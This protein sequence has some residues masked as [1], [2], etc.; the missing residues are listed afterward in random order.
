[1]RTVLR[2]TTTTIWISTAVLLTLVQMAASVF[3]RRGLALTTISDV[4][5]ALLFLCL[6]LAF[7]QNAVPARGR[8]RVFWILQSLG[9]FISLINQVWWMV[10]DIILQKPVPMLFLGDV[11]LFLPS[12]LMLAGFLLQPHFEQPR[13]SAR[14]GTLDF[15]LLTFWWVFL[16]VYL[17]SCW[18]FI[19]PNEYLY[20]RNYDQLYLTEILVVLTVL[21]ALIRQTSD[22]WRR[23]YGLYSAAILFNYIWFA[24]ENRAIENY[25]YFV[26]S[27]YDSPYVASFACF[28]FVAL[29]GR[30]LEL[31]RE[32]A[33][34]KQRGRW[35]TASAILAVLSLPAMVL[36]A[37]LERGVSLEIMHFRV[38]VTALAMLVMAAL[39][40]TKQQILHQELMQAN[41]VLEESSTTDPLT[42]IRNRRFLSANI[43]HDIAQ[44]LRTHREQHGSSERDLI[45]YL[46]DLDNFKKVNDRYGHD[47]G[48]RVLIEAARRIS[49]AIRDSDLLVR[50]GGEEFL[51]VSRFTDRTQSGILAQRVL[52]AFRA[53]PFAASP[54]DQVLQT[55]SVGWAAFPWFAHDVDAIGYEGVLKF[56]DRGLYRAKKGGKNRA[57]GMIPSADGANPVESSESV[58]NALRLPEPTTPPEPSDAHQAQTATGRI[59]RGIREFRS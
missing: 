3:L 58:T 57:V 34:L 45:F 14:L 43:Q 24:F 11:L 26:G 53:K 55:C 22:T 20:N 51:V 21:V 15:L 44:S 18:Q 5:S 35:I 33:S 12:L 25:T 13:R 30:D 50:W 52:D 23:F 38:L 47:G 10:Y 40:F 56:A 41:L 19:S 46:I 7:A 36:Y 9:W 39:V 37:A 59:D 42:G 49:S 6:I 29:Y 32:R 27:W 17:V 48:D 8:L 28:M 16:Y 54:T 2:R 1:M 4:A 31:R